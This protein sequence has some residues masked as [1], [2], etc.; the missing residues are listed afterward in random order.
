MMVASILGCVYMVMK[1]GSNA[2]HVFL[3]RRERHGGS[4]VIISNKN[5]EVHYH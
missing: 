4:R 2:I 3:L 1:R 5:Q